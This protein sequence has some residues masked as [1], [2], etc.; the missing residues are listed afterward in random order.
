MEKLT[1]KT[2]VVVYTSIYRSDGL[3]D[4]L[5]SPLFTDPNF[6]Y[7]CFTPH[8]DI[9]AEGWK[10]IRTEWNEGTTP[11]MQA[12]KYK[13]FPHLY[14]HGYL[15]SIWVDGSFAI[16]SNL[17]E[18]LL[19]TMKDEEVPFVFFENY[20]DDCAYD[21]AEFCVKHRIGNSLKILSQMASYKKDGFPRHF[22]LPMC[23]MMYRKHYLPIM[24]RLMESW[25]YEIIAHSERDQLSLPYVLWRTE[26]RAPYK[27]IKNPKKRL[28]NAYFRAYSRKRRYNEP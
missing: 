9:E 7:I 24:Q 3:K 5:H 16:K 2:R 6:D 14:L 12:K 15:H 17:R 13:L 10:I 22:G 19:K 26:G 27:T 21:S 23:G 4:T 25:W 1:N 18:L 11:R 8:G 28:W 20:Q